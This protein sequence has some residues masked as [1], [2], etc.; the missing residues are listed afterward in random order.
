MLVSVLRVPAALPAP[1]PPGP[2]GIRKLF[3]LRLLV[4][5][6]LC[7]Q[8]CFRRLI[9]EMFLEDHGQGGVQRRMFFFNWIE[10][11]M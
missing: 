11:E 7:P 5:Q 6:P 9:P 3:S 2:L 10:A 4:S 8:P 1:S